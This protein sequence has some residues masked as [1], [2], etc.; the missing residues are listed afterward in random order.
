MEL[1]KLTR[2]VPLSPI[3]TSVLEDMI[4]LIGKRQKPGIR[5][6]ATRNYTST[7]TIIRLAKKLGYSGF[8]DLYYGL[9]RQLGGPVEEHAEEIPF[10]DGFCQ[11]AQE[12]GRQ[13]KARERL[14]QA[15]NEARSMMVYICGMGFSSFPAGYFSQKLMVQGVKCIFS[16]AEESVGIF[17][18]NLEDIHL[19]IA[20]SRSGETGK[21]LERVRLARQQKIMIATFT[22]QEDSTLARMSDIVLVVQDSEKLDDRNQNP[23]FFFAGTLLQMELVIEELRRDRED[24]DRKMK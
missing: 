7:T 22:A 5:T 16:G 20:V 19:F 4:T 13:Q 21:V 18:S 23:S 17:E 24:D 10:L 8:T 6:L 14:A 9:Q 11:Q 12:L 3:E 1:E 15:L 2:N